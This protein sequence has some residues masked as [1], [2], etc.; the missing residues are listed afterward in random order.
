MKRQHW[1]RIN[2]I[3]IALLF[4]YSVACGVLFTLQR[5]IIF[6][7]K[8]EMLPLAKDDRAR[9]PYK[10]VEIAVPN[11]DDRLRGWWIKAPQPGN[12]I[13][14]LPNEPV[15]VVQDKTILFLHGAGGNKSYFRR[16]LEGLRQLGFAIFAIDYRGYGESKGQF[17]SEAQIYADS[18]LAWNHLTQTRKIPPSQ[19][20]IYGESLGGAIAINLAKNHPDAGGVIVQSSFT[21]MAAIAQHR[22]LLPLFPVSLLLTQRF[23]SIAKVRHLQVPILFIHGT[24]DETVPAEMSQQLYRAAPQPKQLLLI[25]NAGHNS[26]YRS[27]KDSYLKA[28]Q[29]FVK[30]IP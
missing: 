4:S 6:S 30:A 17:P 3:A 19:I 16:R 25:P 9:L 11:S 22:P 14:I 27:G 28:I 24:A 20:V 8:Q 21:S 10:Q 1:N 26:I 5:H 18:E 23:D 12:T 7:P 13:S 2:R 29:Q 15:R